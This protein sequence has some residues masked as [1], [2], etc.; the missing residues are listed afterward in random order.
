MGGTGQII[1]NTLHGGIADAVAHKISPTLGNI[2]D[3]GLNAGAAIAGGP[4]STAASPATA[5]PLQLANVLG[6]SAGQ[7]GTLSGALSPQML[8]LIQ[9]LSQRGG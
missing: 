1:G 9:M 8:R 6:P 4:A 2:Y 7:P 5:S 3:T